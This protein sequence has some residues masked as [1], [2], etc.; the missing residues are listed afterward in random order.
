[1]RVIDGNAS[2]DEEKEPKKA[3]KAYRPQCRSDICEEGR[4]GAKWLG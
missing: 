2:E 3:Q 4:K 1:M